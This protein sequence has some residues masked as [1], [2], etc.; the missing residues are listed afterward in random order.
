LFFYL[1]EGPHS[2]L[3]EEEFFDALDQSLDRIDRETDNYQ[4]L[5]SIR[6]LLLLIY[7]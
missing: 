7:P 3:K 1:K 6:L 2:A 4:R 5:V